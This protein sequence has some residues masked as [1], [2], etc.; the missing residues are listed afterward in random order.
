MRTSQKGRN[1]MKKSIKV[2]FTLL[3][4]ALMALLP[5]TAG[6]EGYLTGPELV[7]AVR[8]SN[9]RL[10]GFGA[11]N[12][13][14]SYNAIPVD[15]ET[16]D[17][18]VAKAA[19]V[20][21]GLS[22]DREKAEA[23]NRWVCENVYYDYDYYYHHTKSYPNYMPK[24]VFE[25]GIA[26]CSG[27]A[28][29][30]CSMLR[31]V[32]IPARL[33]A[34][35]NYSEPYEYEKRSLTHDWV[36]VYFD[37]KWNM[38]DPTWDSRNKYEFGKK[39][40]GPYRGTYFAMEPNEF[41]VSHFIVRYENDLKIGDYIYSL[42]VDEIKIKQ[43][44][45]D[46][47][48]PVN[49]VIPEGVTSI[50]DRA[51]MGF[52]NLT[53]VKLPSTLKSIGS[54]VFSN[55]TSLETVE[56]GGALEEIGN[57][58]FSGCTLL[59]SIVFPE[60]LKK[61]GSGAFNSCTLLKT[62]AFPEG[63]K[64]VGGNAFNGCTA[65]ESVY[66]PDSVTSIGSDA[67]KNCAALKSVHIGAGVTSLS[68]SCFYSCKNLETITGGENIVSIGQ[69]CFRYDEKYLGNDFLMN[70]TYMGE[71]ALQGCKSVKRFRLPK[72]NIDN[73]S[74][75]AYLESLEEVVI[76]EGCWDLPGSLFY[77]CKNLKKINI[78]SSVTVF[79]SSL[80]G[81]CSSLE[82]IT[83]PDGIK[84]VKTSTFYNCKALKTVY[85]PASVTLIDSNAFN[86]CASLSTVYFSGTQ[87]QWNQIT[88]NS[89]N[90]ALKN[91]TVVFGHEHSFE[92]TRI[93][94]A[95][96]T[97]TGLV[98]SACKECGFMSIVTESK[99]GHDY[100]AVKTVAPTCLT[101]GYTVYVC[102][103]CGDSVNKDETAPVGHTYGLIVEIEADCERS[104]EGHKYCTVCKE[105]FYTEKETIPKLGHTSGSWIIDKEADCENPGA[106]H[107]ECTRCNKTIEEQTIAKM[108]HKPDPWVLVQA[109]T[110]SRPGKMQRTCTVCKKVVS[111]KTLPVISHTPG[112][113]IIDKAASCTENGARHKVC[114]ACGV[115]VE[116]GVIS[117]NG[118]SWGQWITDK[119]AT[120]SEKGAEHS[121]CTKCG[122]VEK[123]TVGTVPHKARSEWETVVEPLCNRKGLE[124]LKCKNCNAVIESRA[125]PT[126]NHVDNDGDNICD[127]C[128]ERI[129]G[130]SSGSSCSHMCHK[131]GF[132]GFIWKLVNLFNKLFKIN[133]ECSCGKYHW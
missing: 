121:T 4:I 5:L 129:K 131:D 101:G 70:L 109:A 113:W 75:F 83:V 52:E 24:V 54:N 51:F 115:T 12:M 30:F 53:S 103:V 89:G 6:A 23:L 119:E 1:V 111:T 90:N 124:E 112:E 122:A 68:D 64:T 106:R 57:N 108:G 37:G 62:V 104:G 13:D 46:T 77:G 56:F 11:E 118:H 116:T 34:G 25:T 38:C 85:I 3:L 132:S 125:I 126:I 82:S 86:F 63:L 102:N 81:G 49:A 127:V 117:A 58:A 69:Y 95:T 67:F 45:G 96:C 130:S 42:S 66:V 50:S 71:Y 72:R 40:D 35:S 99:L 123:R 78:P 114:T 28:R 15:I 16:T 17:E 92:T 93:S 29:L 39:V 55:C 79:G 21:A 65:L 31:A 88:V 47:S 8:K 27:Y 80:F 60:G 98:K 87:E 74:N 20:T 61:I 2:L 94:D 133:K 18:I 14:V 43:Y 33:V 22:T 128:S 110:C 120:C 76:S 84:A 32:G 48:K 107:K 105:E 44:V 97:D 19:E 36:E 7:D 9:L 41:S 73:V 91:A 26:V 59:K 10:C 100:K